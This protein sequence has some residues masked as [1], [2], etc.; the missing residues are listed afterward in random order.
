MKLLLIWLLVLMIVL[1]VLYFVLNKLYDYFSLKES[2]HNIEIQNEVAQ[3]Q[4]ELNQAAL[5]S[6][7]KMLEREIFAKSDMIEDLAEIK[8]LEKELDEV[9]ELI[10]TISKTN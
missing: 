7:K 3:R 8:Q 1:V 9:N 5:K 10:D 2:L 4:Y 6:K